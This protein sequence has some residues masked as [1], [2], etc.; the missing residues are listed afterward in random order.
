VQLYN[1][2]IVDVGT[3]V[4]LVQ[5]PFFEACA[6]G[7]DTEESITMRLRPDKVRALLGADTAPA[8]PQ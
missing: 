7:D 1:R 3:I 8:L 4:P 2:G 5:A 6:F